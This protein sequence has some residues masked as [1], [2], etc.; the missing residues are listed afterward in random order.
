MEE[1]P[2]LSDII[3]RAI[4]A[5]F[6]Y[7]EYPV[8]AA[9]KAKKRR[10]I[11]IGVINYAYWMAKQGFSFSGNEGNNATHELFEVLQYHLLNASAELAGE[12]GPCEYFN[13][14]EYSLGKLPIDWYNKNADTVH[15]AELKQDWEAL[16]EKISE[17][18]LRNST[19]TA[20]MPAETSAMVSGATNG[21]EPVRALTTSKSS[22]DGVFKT[23]VPEV[24]KL[25]DQ[26]EIVWSMGNNDGYIEKVAIMQKF[27]DQAISANTNYNPFNYPNNLVPVKTIISDMVKAYKLG[28]KT[29]YYHNTYDGSGEDNFKEDDGCS[30]G[31]CRI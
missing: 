29:L 20:I 10:S 4:D 6:D 14:T 11:G 28:V 25:F 7:Q 16:R 21:I 27:V 17:Y 12:K 24:Q 13:Q 18:G 15:T 22:K 30:G 9:E 31:G 26:Y 2:E 23:V 19:L 5:L 3:V 8:K 1:L